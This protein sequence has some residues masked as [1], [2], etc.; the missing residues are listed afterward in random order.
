MAAIRAFA[1]TGRS[2][3][4]RANDLGVKHVG[5]GAEVDHVEDRH[6]LTQLL[7]R[8][9]ERSAQLARVEPSTGP[10]ALD[11]DAGKRDQPREALGPDRRIGM[12]TVL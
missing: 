12:V 6:V 9:V 5:A 7:L 8:D 2:R 11:Q 10:A 3:A 1:S 4:G